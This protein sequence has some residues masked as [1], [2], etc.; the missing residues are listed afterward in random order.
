MHSVRLMFLPLLALTALTPLRAQ[1]AASLP[2]AAVIPAASDSV[3][4]CQTGD[5]IEV[6]GTFAMTRDFDTCQFQADDAVVATHGPA[7][8]SDPYD[9]HWTAP[10]PGEHLLQ[11]VYTDQGQHRTFGRKLVVLV[12]N[13]PPVAFQTLPA[14]A[15]A[16]TAVSVV[17][18][19]AFAP[20][21][22]YFYFD[23]QPITASVSDSFTAILPIAT[24]KQAGSYPLRFVAYDAQGRAF[25][26]R[27]ASVEVLPR[28]KIS[29]PATFSLEKP[30]DRAALTADIAPDVKPAKVAYFWSASG[31]D[32]WQPL[33]E[34]SSAP[35][36]FAFDLSAFA[37]NDYQIK[38]TL[39]TVSGATY[40]AAPVTLTF[41]NAMA[42][43]K[44]AREAKDKADADALL[45]AQEAKKQADDTARVA[46]AA[47]LQAERAANLVRFLPRPGFDTAIFRKQLAELALPS[48]PRAVLPARQ[49]ATGMALGLDAVPGAA[50]SV[51]A[52]PASAH[53]SPGVAAIPQAVTVFVQPGSGQINYPGGVAPLSRAIA[54]QALDY[55][56]SQSS[57]TGWGW[58][59]HD[60]TF[61]LS[62][63]PS[64]GPAQGLAD[65][66]ALLSAVSNHAVDDSVVLSGAINAQG[67]VYS[68]GGVYDPLSVFGNPH[69]HTLL[70]PAG[71]IP[72][73]TLFD[74]YARNPALCFG[75]RVVLV[76]SVDAA[77]RYAVI[78]WPGSHYA[79]EESLIQGGLRH[80]AAGDDKLALAAFSAAKDL[81]PDNW[82]AGFWMTMVNLV[83]Q[84]SLKKPASI[85]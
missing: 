35:F 53:S 7:A 85:Q 59:Q 65:A 21:R 17:G 56:K 83:Q 20:V 39:T 54:Q 60:I 46:D 77:L 33:G 23:G 73:T 3:V 57:A 40:D 48:D 25:Y 29:A 2:P 50:H 11:V 5:S 76:H 66:V 58:T 18:T 24:K 71:S 75:R 49:G 47:H 45:A 80:F 79:K 34:A 74:L 64:A 30:D 16:D 14:K 62:A 9:F 12:S 61:Q 78:N 1:N 72:E 68:V 41:K 43:D 32:D 44:A 36:S 38:A 19:S 8:G 70:V 55:G 28:L 31:A 67:D 63:S 82:T 4:A 27:T 42:A 69:I 22:V 84:Q 52:V 13:A 26:S 37:D 81:D 6:K 51:R 15:G 10:A